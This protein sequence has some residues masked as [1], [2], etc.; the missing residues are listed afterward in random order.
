MQL[1]ALILASASPVRALMLREAGLVFTVMP[2]PYDEEAQK[3]TIA[4]LLPADQAA[5]LARGK[6]EAVSGLYPDAYVIGADQVC[7]MGRRIFGKPGTFARA[8]AH[9]RA[10]QGGEHFQHSAACVYL[11]GALQWEMLETVT[12]RMKPLDE[13]AIETYLTA[14]KPLAACGAYA[15]EK[16]GHTLFETV[17]GSA[18]AIKGLPLDGLLKFLRGF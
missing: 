2:S 10:L 5:F 13:K 3:E 7:A 15:Y 6:A 17:Q 16:T 18:A 8:T 11:R 14:D 9:L 1:S 12:L 4:H